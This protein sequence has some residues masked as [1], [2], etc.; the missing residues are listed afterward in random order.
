[1]GHCKNSV[2]NVLKSLYLKQFTQY[3]LGLLV[4]DPQTDNFPIHLH[5]VV[6]S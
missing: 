3:N 6:L 5:G 2:H 4:S 1:M